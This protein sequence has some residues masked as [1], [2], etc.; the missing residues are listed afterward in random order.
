MSEAVHP[1][2]EGFDARIGPRELAELHDLADGRSRPLLARPGAAADLEQV[3]DQGRRLVVRRARF[4]HPLVR[5]RRAQPVGQLPRPPPRRARRPHRDHLR[6]RRARPGPRLDLPPALRRDLPL[7]QSAEAARHR[8]RRPGDDLH[9][10][11]PRSGGGDAR[12]R[13]DRRDPLGRVRRLLARKPRRPHRRLRRVRGDHRRRGRARRQ[14]HPAE[15]QRR[16]RA[17]PAATCRP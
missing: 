9:A 14:A 16:H 2:P 15:A 12:L 4:P 8:A 10:D 6:G 3:P 13:A 17:R 1:V 5:R 7:R 11:D